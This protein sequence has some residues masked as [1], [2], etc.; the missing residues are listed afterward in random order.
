MPSTAS[1]RVMRGIAIPAVAVAAVAIAAFTLDGHDREH[2]A[3]RCRQAGGEVL[4][5]GL[6]RQVACV[7]PGSVIDLGRPA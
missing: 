5:D 3:Q 1:R 6:E 7:K 4:H 2:F